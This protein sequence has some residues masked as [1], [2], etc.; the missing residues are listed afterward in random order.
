MLDMAAAMIAA[1][2][3]PISPIGR[4]VVTNVGNT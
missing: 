2:M 1:I 4:C 3:I